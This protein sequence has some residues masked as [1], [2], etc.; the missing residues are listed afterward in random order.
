MS[1]K[2][3][4]LT[5]ES[6]AF[7]ER[8]LRVLD[9]IAR[10]SERARLEQELLTSA[11][12]RTLFVR[13]NLHRTEVIAACGRLDAERSQAEKLKGDVLARIGWGGAGSLAAIL[14][15][16]L[17]LGWLLTGNEGPK[18][19]ITQW[20]QGQL[21]ALTL[22]VDDSGLMNASTRFFR[23][24]QTLRLD[25]GVARLETPAGV[26]MIVD[27]PATIGFE[28][29][30]S[31]RLNAGRMVAWV[32]DGAE[33]FAIEVKGGRVVDLGT[34]F[35]VDVDAV[36]GEILTHVFDGRVCVE[37]G[38]SEIELTG[39]QEVRLMPGGLFTGISS[40]SGLVGFVREVPRTQLAA[41]IAGFA[42]LLYYSFDDQGKSG[43]LNMFD[44]D[45]SP[46][47]FGTGGRRDEREGRTFLR[48][49]GQPE[50]CYAKGVL[51]PW[52]RDA[53]GYTVLLRVRP[54]E[55]GSQNILTATNTLGPDRLFG[56][57]LRIR[58]DGQLEHVTVVRGPAGPAGEVV[59]SSDIRISQGQWVTLAITAASEGIMRLYVDGQEA[60]SPV[61]LD[62]SLYLGYPDLVVGG[63][64]GRVRRD[65]MHHVAGFSGEVDDLVVI[66]RQ[67]TDADLAKIH[68][69]M[70]PG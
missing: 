4:A 65:V 18:R 10:D 37:S 52:S 62:A 68:G 47:A 57:Q 43:S 27:G 16:G 33:G 59:Q 20:T 40:G 3:A 50:G 67:L 30:R 70:N 54:I 6:D 66:A 7:V 53:S 41:V 25:Q 29:A 60:A 28:R 17:W 11:E 45:R 48:L 14:L 49:S 26:E 8:S 22:T 42:P 58:P 46:L 39:G 9:G 69:Y 19:E 31:V 2:G 44:A 51:S 15:L 56:P 36:T 5:P 13:L 35:G 23:S 55:P 24:G 34:R 12:R 21:A 64:A 38:A 63:S 61:D 1:K 32:P